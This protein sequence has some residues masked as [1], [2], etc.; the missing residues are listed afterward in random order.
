MPS[1]VTFVHKCRWNQSSSSANPS[2]LFVVQVE[3]V[4][5]ALDDAQFLLTRQRLVEHV[6]AADGLHLVLSAVDHKRGRLHAREFVPDV[7]DEAVTSWT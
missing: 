1:P 6:R 2:S 5:A 7:H 3:Q 4:A